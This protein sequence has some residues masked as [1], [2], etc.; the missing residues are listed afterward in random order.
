MLLFIFITSIL[1]AALP[2]LSLCL[3]I[4]VNFINKS[5]LYTILGT[6]L[7]MIIAIFSPMYSYVIMYWLK[8]IFKIGLTIPTE[9]GVALIWISLFISLATL[10]AS[11]IYFF[12]LFI[13]NHLQKKNTAT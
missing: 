9:M 5:L 2:L 10:A 8:D 7:S 11:P 4:T 12:A 1:V 13:S 3:T 6:A